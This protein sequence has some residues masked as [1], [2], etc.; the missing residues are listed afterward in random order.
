MG[1][2]GVNCLE[3]RVEMREDELMEAMSFITG[4][5][6]H[7]QVSTDLA[8]AERVIAAGK[9]RGNYFNEFHTHAGHGRIVKFVM[10]GVFYKVWIARDGSARL[11]TIEKGRHNYGKK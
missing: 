4:L 9:Q 3:R 8:T 1:R 6:A 7:N 10:Q 2:V 11:T 5:K